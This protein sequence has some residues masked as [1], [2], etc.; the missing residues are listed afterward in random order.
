MLPLCAYACDSQALPPRGMANLHDY[1]IQ[2]VCDD[3]A[4]NTGMQLRI[5]SS[6]FTSCVCIASVV[7]N[8]DSS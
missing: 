8:A 4:C 2:I 7:T 5:V 6:H 3:M 1:V